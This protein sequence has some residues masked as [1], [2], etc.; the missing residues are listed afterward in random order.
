MDG[1]EDVLARVSMV[2]VDGECIYD[3]YV[4]PKQHITNYRTEVSGIRPHNL[5]NG[6]H[7]EVFKNRIISFRIGIST[8]RKLALLAAISIALVKV[9][10]HQLLA[11]VM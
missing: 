7:F 8:K 3:K 10:L 4:K 1:S 11:R 6:S 2:N 5:L 9:L